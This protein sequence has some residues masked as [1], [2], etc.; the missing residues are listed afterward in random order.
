L[1]ALEMLVNT[2][3][4]KERKLETNMSLYFKTME[5][6]TKDRGY[7]LEASTQPS[8][9]SCHYFTVIQKMYPTMI[10]TKEDQTFPW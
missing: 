3:N 6:R 8:Y 4:K 1:K 2:V 7:K 10:I 9:S 5:V